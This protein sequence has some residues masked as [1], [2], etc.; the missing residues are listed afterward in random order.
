M[1]ALGPSQFQA[2]LAH[3]FGHLSG[4]HSKFGAWIYRV[5][6]TWQQLI[7][8]LEQRESL[9]VKLF[10]YFFEWYAPFFLAYS[11]VLARAQEYE[12]DRSAAEIVGARA[13]A[14]AL[15]KLEVASAF[16]EERF[17]PGIFSKADTEPVPQSS[18]FAEMK[19]AFRSQ[20]PIDSTQNWL[21]DAM[22]RKT[23]T[24]DTHP[25]LSDRLQ[26]LGEEAE[27]VRA[28][29]VS[30]AEHFFGESLAG[31]AATADRNWREA[32]T[33][34]WHARHEQAREAERRVREL[35]AKG[36]R[37]TLSDE[38]V[39][40]LATLA[41]EFQG[42]A[43]ALPWFEEM[44]RRQPNH[45]QAA[46]RIGQQMLADNREE[47]INV[48]ERAMKLDT[49]LVIHG[50]SLIYDYLITQ[51]REDEA[52]AYQNKRSQ[53]AEMVELA[54][55]ER[56][57]IGLN[58]RY[59]SHGLA[60]EV[61]EDFTRQLSL[62]NQIAKAYMVRKEVK[63]FSEFPVY[64]LAVEVKRAWY[65][66]GAPEVDAQLRQDLLSKVN[67]PG[68][69]FVLTASDTTAKLVDLMRLVPDSLIY[70]AVKPSD[71]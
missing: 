54:E 35:E 52:S 26:A 5:R 67:F 62:F 23:G 58:D 34:P 60:P 15:I 47:G 10:G 11:F 64:A 17:W 49:R 27:A 33:L 13:T 14:D 21:T 18:P 55:E 20:L 68:E 6:L 59:L 61:V 42:S 71:S 8:A 45:A 32:V 50:C 37:E 57:T 43:T 66:T 63:Y 46:F 36:P 2:I 56:S 19:Q 48:I 70:E 1:Q 31:L 3:E 9:A 4:S 22:N 69:T 28:E 53:Q 12:A 29:S 65:S 51:K 40:E 30:A 39:W 44:L 24:A 25:S 38:E 7:D 16:L 41:D